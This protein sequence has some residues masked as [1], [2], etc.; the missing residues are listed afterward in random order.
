MGVVGKEGRQVNII[1][2]QL[3]MC[4]V[5]VLLLLYEI[6]FKGIKPIY[7]LHLVYSVQASQLGTVAL[8][9]YLVCPYRLCQC[10]YR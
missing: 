7:Y 5:I 3:K 4:I 2:K 10:S 6:D 8:F 1:H 9:M